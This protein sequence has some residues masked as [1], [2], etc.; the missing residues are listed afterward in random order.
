MLL[1]A[2]ALGEFAKVAI[3]DPVG[4]R[5]HLL[6]EALRLPRLV[7][8]NQEDRRPPGI[9]GEEDPHRLGDP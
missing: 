1:A 5:N 4:D 7:S 8:P 2:F 6:V 9:E 3:V